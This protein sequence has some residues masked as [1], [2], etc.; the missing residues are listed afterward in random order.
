VSEARPAIGPQW[1]KANILGGV[2][3]VVV[4]SVGRL[5][6]WLLGIEPGFAT[7]IALAV[8]GI[9]CVAGQA[10]GLVIIGYLTGIVLRRKLPMFSMRSWLVL[11]GAIGVLFGLVMTT[12]WLEEPTELNTMGLDRLTVLAVGAV[13]LGILGALFG[14]VEGAL[15]A[16]ILRKAASGL[17]AWVAYSA[18]AG[19]TTIVMV[20]FV[21]YS[22]APGFTTEVMWAAAGFLITFAIAFI[23]L[24]AVNQL[25]PR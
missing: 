17:K 8:V 16:F 7:H 24:P 23:M 13:G 20:P 1:I 9:I 5:I 15:Q 12:E 4:T 25:R 19:T 18:L 21:V 3:Y 14:A 11:Y 22:P 6:I 10:F 2:V